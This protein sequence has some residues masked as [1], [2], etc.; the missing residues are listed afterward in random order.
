M[1]N[2]LA[3][4]TEVEISFASGELGLRCVPPLQVPL[5]VLFCFVLSQ[6]MS[7]QPKPAW[8]NTQPKLGLNL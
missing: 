8:N 6:G 5:V 3:E 2:N 4:P 1:P 7:T